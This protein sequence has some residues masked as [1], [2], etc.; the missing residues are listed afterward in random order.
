V[1]CGGLIQ[2]AEAFL[3]TLAF[4]PYFHQ[5]AVDVAELALYL[6]IAG[7]FILID[8]DPVPRQHHL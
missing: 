2:A 6:P 8:I 7:Y 3:K 4:M 5:F 1:S